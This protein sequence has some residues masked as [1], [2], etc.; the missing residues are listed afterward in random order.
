MPTIPSMQMPMTIPFSP[1][2][3]STLSKKNY[4]SRLHPMIPLWLMILFQIGF[5]P[6][7][8]WVQLLESTN[9]EKYFSGSS[10][11]TWYENRSGSYDERPD[12][13]NS[14]YYHGK[15]RF[16]WCCG[17]SNERVLSFDLNFCSLRF[18]KKPI[19]MMILKIVRRSWCASW[20]I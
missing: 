18:L 20:M 3:P 2:I 4:L 16:D 6:A 10:S 19:N 9:W 5:N 8:K 14:H 12:N 15:N 7:D 13:N 17:M 1:R 11:Y